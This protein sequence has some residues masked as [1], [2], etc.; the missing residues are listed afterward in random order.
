LSQHTVN[1]TVEAAYP[2]LKA[3][4]VAKGCKIASETPPNQLSVRQGSLWGV[5]P[6]TAKKT[7]NIMLE[8]TEEK[9]LIKYYSK[10]SSDW[11]NITV[12]GCILAF[13]LAVICLWMA[14]DLGYFLDTGNPSFWSWL[15]TARGQVEF[16]AGEAFVNLAWG[17]AVF[18]FIII[19]AEAVVYF[20]CGSK[21]ETFASEAIDEL[22]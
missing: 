4:L 18:L 20:Y 12:I 19:A 13:A 9:T 8:G 2:K 22:A 16:Q 7:V 10:L 21:V 3:L 17:L 5:A 6:R 1:L 15:V 14:T 11:K